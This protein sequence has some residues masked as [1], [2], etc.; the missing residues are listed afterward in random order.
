MQ[1]LNQTDF[2]RLSQYLKAHYGINLT[3]KKH[4]I[5][6]RLGNM[7]TQ[8]GFSDFT[9]YV[10]HILTNASQDDLSF[11]LSKLTT[12]HTYF[13][14]ENEHFTFLRENVLPV[15]KANCRTKAPAIWSAGCSSGEE[16]YTISM[17]LL[18]YFGSEPGRWDTRILAT[19]ISDQVLTKARAGSYSKDSLKDIPTSWLQKYFTQSGTSYQASEKLRKNI[20]FRKFNLMDDIKFKAKFDVIFCRNVMIYFEPPVKEA[21]VRRFYNAMNPG[22]FLFI[23]HSETLNHANQPFKYIQPSVY[24]KL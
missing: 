14:R 1:Q 3:E 21:L 5:E 19:D 16:P 22:G 10:D 17:I 9:E 24:R 7:I 15:L 4:L 12:N 6:S 8:K 20:D 2:L 23:G 11:L 18:D 13:M